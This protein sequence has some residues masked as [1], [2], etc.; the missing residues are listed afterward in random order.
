MRPSPATVAD[1]TEETRRRLEAAG[2]DTR[3]AAPLIPLLAAALLPEPSPPAEEAAPE[4]ELLRYADA[5]RFLNVPIGTLY[6]W[7]NQERVPCVRIGPKSVRFVRSE[8]VAWIKA[9]NGR[10]A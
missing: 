3:T 10:A 8:L 1:A 4:E 7:V 9:R 6:N 2:F 5:A